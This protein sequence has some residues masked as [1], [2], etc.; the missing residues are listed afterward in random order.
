MKLQDILGGNVTLAAYATDAVHCLL[1]KGKVLKHLRIKG[2]GL[3]SGSIHDGLPF[4]TLCYVLPQFLSDEG[5]DGMDELQEGLKELKGGLL[6]FRV[7][8]LSVCG[9]DC[10]K[11]PGAV[12]VPEEL[13]DG[14]EGI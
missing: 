2:L 10:L 9:L 1:G 12:V 7:N 8:G 11:I 3:G 4:L 6:G 14:H 5:H 13:V